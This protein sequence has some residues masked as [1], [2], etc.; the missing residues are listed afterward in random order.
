MS[1]G[2]LVSR[3]FSDPGNLR[4]D[5]NYFRIMLTEQDFRESRG[6]SERSRIL[7]SQ[8]IITLGLCSRIMN[9]ESRDREAIR[10]HSV[11][12]QV[13]HRELESELFRDCVRDPEGYDPQPLV[14]KF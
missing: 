9:S 11:K 8:R 13:R 5:S 4:I 1:F 12:A 7:R 10:V 14:T 2:E 3:G 6:C